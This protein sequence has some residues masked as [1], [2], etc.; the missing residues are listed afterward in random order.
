MNKLIAVLSISLGVLA[1]CAQH[2]PAMMKNDGMKKNDSTMRQDPMQKDCAMEKS[3][4]PGQ[5]CM[6]KK[7]GSMKGTQ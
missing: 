1:G 7:E 4:T 3:D 5:E 2:G 6:M